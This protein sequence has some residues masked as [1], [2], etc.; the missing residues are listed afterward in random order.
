MTPK[1]DKR[2]RLGFFACIFI[3]IFLGIVAGYWIRWVT[4]PVLRISN[5]ET[6]EVYIQKNVSSGDQLYFGWIHS[7][8]KIPWNEF[9]HID[10]DLHIVLDTIS[11]PAFGAGI[12]ENKGRVCEVVDGMIYMSEINQEFS[13]FAWINSHTAV[14]EIHIDGRY[15]TRGSDLPDHVRLRLKVEGRLR[16]EG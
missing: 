13:E 10:D 3:L 12:P 9:Y 11:F 1:T 8:E 14:Q 15:F 5:W 16:C 7:Q 2:V 4:R 6:G